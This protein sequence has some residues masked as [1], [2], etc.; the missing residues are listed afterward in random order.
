MSKYLFRLPANRVVVDGVPLPFGEFKDTK[1]FFQLVPDSGGE[2]LEVFGEPLAYYP[3]SSIRWLKILTR[4]NDQAGVYHLESTNKLLPAQPQYSIKRRQLADALKAYVAADGNEYHWVISHLE[5]VASYGPYQEE[6]EAWGWLKDNQNN[7]YTWIEL[8]LFHRPAIKNGLFEVWLRHSNMQPTGKKRGALQIDKFEIQTGAGFSAYMDPSWHVFYPLV[9]YEQIIPMK[10]SFL[11]DSQSQVVRF[12][13]TMPGVRT[14]WGEPADYSPS[15]ILGFQGH[16]YHESDGVLPP[17]NVIGNGEKFLPHRLKPEDRTFTRYQTYLN[18]RQPGYGRMGWFQDTPNLLGLGISSYE[19]MLLLAASELER[20]VQG[21]YPSEEGDGKEEWVV[22]TE[23]SGDRYEYG[24]PN[25]RVGVNP[26]PT[27]DQNSMLE[28]ISLDPRA[29]RLHKDTKGRGD[30]YNGIDMEHGVLPELQAYIRTG[31][32]WFKERIVAKAEC[33]KTIPGWNDAAHS[34]RALAYGLGVMLNAMKVSQNWT[35]WEMA[36][37]FMEANLTLCGKIW[38][39]D[40]WRDFSVNGVNYQVLFGNGNGNS[41]SGCAPWMGGQ[42]IQYFIAMLL[43]DIRIAGN[44]SSYSPIDKRRVYEVCVDTM[45][46]YWRYAYDSVSDG[47]FWYKLSPYDLSKEG[48]PI[49]N[50]SRVH[51]VYGIGSMLFWFA[52]LLPEKLRAWME[53]SLR[54][55]LDGS[56]RDTHNEA[57]F[58]HWSAA[59]FRYRHEVLDRRDM[60]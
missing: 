34:E 59:G 12:W 42:A 5:P 22:N 54:G 48:D 28:A 14:N 23:L 45:R 3:D 8:Y 29:A 60:K 40:G 6:W 35:Y 46:F 32:P 43:E 47:G 41:W 49:W 20:P 31:I 7:R 17:L 25:L 30:I 9:T 4:T 11:Q 50:S 55:L 1:T 15:P 19:D 36:R 24:F 18:T 16:G 53:D 10:D 57:G 51:L 38:T 56:L 39:P 44:D 58:K 27:P 2:P 52:K 13:L 33:A 26:R 21:N 37:N